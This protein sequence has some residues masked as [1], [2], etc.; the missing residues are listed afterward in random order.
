MKFLAAAFLR[1]DE[2]C[3]FQNCD[4]L[5]YRLSRH[6]LLLAKL[7]QRLAV[8]GTET[9]QQ[10]P[11]HRIG[12]RAEYRIHAHGDNMQPNSCLLQVNFEL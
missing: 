1:H 6:V 8:P 9:I 4:V 7:A 11:P 2:I 3:R 5:R 10:L 12:K